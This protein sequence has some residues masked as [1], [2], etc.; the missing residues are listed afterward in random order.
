M[1]SEAVLEGFHDLSPGL[2]NTSKGDITQYQ[3]SYGLVVGVYD[4]ID[5]V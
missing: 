5:G 2:Y 4:T 1:G 3:G